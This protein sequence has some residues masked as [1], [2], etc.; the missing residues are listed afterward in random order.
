[1]LLQ[2]TRYLKYFTKSSSLSNNLIIWDMID[3][4]FNVIVIKSDCSNIHDFYTS[5][6]LSCEIC[7]YQKIKIYHLCSLFILLVIL[8]N[9]PLFRWIIQLWVQNYLTVRVAL[10]VPP[11]TF[12]RGL[13]V[14]KEM[15]N[16]TVERYEL[17]LIKESGKKKGRLT[18]VSGSPACRCSQL[19]RER[20]ESRWGR[21][22]HTGSP[23]LHFSPHISLQTDLWRYRFLCRL[24]RP[25]GTG[26]VGGQ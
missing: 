8:L 5:I 25:A 12:T 22:R 2:S 14:K 4:N 10:A 1:M 21:S 20:T 6:W 26:T 24:S 16:T 13:P 9:I 11:I 3:H 19:H 7:L 23:Q 15:W 18:L 17:V